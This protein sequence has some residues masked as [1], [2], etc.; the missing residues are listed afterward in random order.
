M[1]TGLASGLGGN[2][3]IG[4]NYFSLGPAYLHYGEDIADV[5]VSLAFMVCFLG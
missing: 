1:G 3:I 2:N 5:S 4:N